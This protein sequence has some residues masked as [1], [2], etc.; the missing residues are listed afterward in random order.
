M[1][2]AHHGVIH[3]LRVYLALE[4]LATEMKVIIPAEIKYYYKR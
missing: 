1:R 3:L 4:Q 2:Y